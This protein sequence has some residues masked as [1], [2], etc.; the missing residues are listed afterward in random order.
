MRI[1]ISSLVGD[2]SQNS[3][4]YQNQVDILLMSVYHAQ[5]SGWFLLT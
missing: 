3:S 5:P 1:E 4:Q 2:A